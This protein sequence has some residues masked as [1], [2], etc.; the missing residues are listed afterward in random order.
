MC[1][2]MSVM[3]V[4]NIEGVSWHSIEY[5]LTV[6]FLFQSEALSSLSQSHV[7]MTKCSCAFGQSEC[8][9]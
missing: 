7:K 3:S 6:A 1:V 8:C 2:Y 4:R 9:I 5:G